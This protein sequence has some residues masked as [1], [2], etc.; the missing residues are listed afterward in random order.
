MFQL[1]PRNACHP[2]K[3]WPKL[4]K[5]IMTLPDIWV[6]WFLDLTGPGKQTGAGYAYVLCN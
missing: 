6:L 1:Q 4:L 3:D 2:V 5:Q